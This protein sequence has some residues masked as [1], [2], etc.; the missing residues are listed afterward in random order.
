MD[1]TKT[2]DRL[3]SP[4]AITESLHHVRNEIAALKELEDNLKSSLLE[5]YKTQLSSAYK[6]KDEPFGVVNFKDGDF[7]ISFT[8]PKKVKYEQRGLARLRDE[9]APVDVEYSIK[10]TVYKD[11]TDEEKAYIIPYRSVEP[12]SVA[13][14][15]ERA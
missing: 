6:Q 9:G 3:N 1:N 15:I 13:I 5:A 14:K 4:E 7:K 2:K 8:T 12:G 10:E 11:M